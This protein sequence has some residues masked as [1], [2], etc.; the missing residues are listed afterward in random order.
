MCIESRAMEN[1]LIKTG[2]LWTI[3]KEETTLSFASAKD[4]ILRLLS[5]ESDGRLRSLLIDLECP[6]FSERIPDV[7]YHHIHLYFQ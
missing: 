6:G 7:M 2:S 5:S 3:D 4:N 1:R